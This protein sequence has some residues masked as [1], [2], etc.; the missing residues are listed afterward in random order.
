MKT[1]PRS[2]AILGFHDGSA[3]QVETW[4]EE[5]TGFRIACFVNE[6]A[7]PLML[8]VTEE[9]KK[10][11][12]QTVDYPSPNSFKDKPLITSLQWADELKR[13][14]VSRVLP[15]TPNNR[16]R[17]EQIE[18]CYARSIALVSAIHPSVTILANAQIADGVWINAGCIIGYKAEIKSGV[19]LNTRS[20]VDHHNVLETC[21]QVDPGVVTA[22]HVTLRKCAHVHTGAV[23]INRV[24]IG[25]DA[26]VGAGAVVLKSVPA[27]TTVVGVPAKGLSPRTTHQ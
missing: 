2:V 17:L 18:I 13:I 12:S 1:D 11:I 25:E 15:L 24:E 8:S 22:G 10:R 26:I 9:N 19:I 3:G 6:A 27:R 14:G 5:V 16:Q 20:Q 23:V 7:S 4:F 21:S